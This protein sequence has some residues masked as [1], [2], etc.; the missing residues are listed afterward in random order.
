[1][2]WHL[3]RKRFSHEYH[4]K[5]YI[6][7]C[8]K[9]FYTRSDIKIQY[10]QCTNDDDSNDISFSLECWKLKNVLKRILLKRL[11]IINLNY[12]LLNVFRFT[13]VINLIFGNIFIYSFTVNF[14]I[15]LFPTFC[16]KLILSLTIFCFR[17]L[18]F[19]RL[20]PPDVLRK[21]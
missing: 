20:I 2:Q 19:F 16:N 6:T 13:L 10:S 21:N 12:L 3:S 14:L 4:T 15:L 7:R 18:G 8:E 17:V 1:M 9:T 5:F 11:K